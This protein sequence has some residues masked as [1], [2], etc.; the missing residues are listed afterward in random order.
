MHKKTAQ[1]AFEL[2]IALIRGY[3]SG[4]NLQ[5]FVG[6]YEQLNVWTVFFNLYINPHR[7]LC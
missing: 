3:V 6:I 7:M 1:G 4:L 2:Q 5:H